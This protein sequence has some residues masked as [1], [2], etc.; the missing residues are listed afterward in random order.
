[1]I[2]SSEKEVFLISDRLYG[3]VR[4]NVMEKGGAE[5][6]E[7]MIN[8]GVD[9]NRIFVDKPTSNDAVKP[10][11]QF[12]KRILGEG[13]ILL[14]K[15]IDS[16]GR[17]NKDMLREWQELI[18]ENKADIRVLDVPLLDTTLHKELLGTFISDLA[19]QIISHVSEQ[20]QESS[21]QGN[22][23][24]PVNGTA[25]GKRPGRPGATFP[26]EWQRVYEKWKLGNITAKKAMEI[27]N[28]KRTTFYKLA[29]M[30]DKLKIGR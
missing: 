9:E 12:L 25:N 29:G 23:E 10:R 14:I 17:N 15:S 24:H 2:L 8:A 19:V 3:Y 18:Y 16:L 30:Y 4:I 20:K 13:D 7:A 6:I 11:L 5:Q 26:E 28:M 1:L 21:K 27:L 22:T